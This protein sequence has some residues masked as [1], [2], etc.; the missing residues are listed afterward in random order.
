MVC[1]WPE[2]IGFD[3][4]RIQIR[5][6]SQITK[7]ILSTAIII[8]FRRSYVRLCSYLIQKRDLPDTDES[9]MFYEIEIYGNLAFFDFSNGRHLLLVNRARSVCIVIDFVK[10]G[11]VL[12]PEQT[13]PRVLRHREN[14]LDRARIPK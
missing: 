2:P 6:L 10:N 5:H 8:L 7:T 9:I 12:L 13:C 4:V 3:A 14:P 1:T 11:I